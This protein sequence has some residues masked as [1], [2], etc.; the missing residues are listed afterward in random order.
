MQWVRPTATETRQLQHRRNP[1]LVCADN[2]VTE[3]KKKHIPQLPC[4][5]IEYFTP[6]YEIQ[7]RKIN[8]R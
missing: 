3:C 6:S 1:F 5:L 4:R 2:M 8:I 7:D